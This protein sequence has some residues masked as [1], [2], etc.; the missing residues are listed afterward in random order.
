[1]ISTRGRYAI[2]V[3]IDL[4][5]NNNGHYI[6]LKDIAK[7]QEISK[8]YLEIIVKEMVAGELLIGASGRGGGYKLR[9]K[10]EEYTVGEILDLMEGT[11]SSVACLADKSFDCPRKTECKTLPM[12]TEYDNLVH[13]FFYGKT[14]LDLVNN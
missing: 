11:L 1:M 12:W 5:E 2:R 14:I 6:P 8:K 7:R 4:V 13:D 3:M 9:R 10:P